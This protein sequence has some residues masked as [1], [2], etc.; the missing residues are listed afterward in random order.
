MDTLQRLTAGGRTV[1]GA[2]NVAQQYH[3]AERDA[4]FGQAFV[5]D[6]VPSGCRVSCRDK[7]TGASKFVRMAWF[8]QE[9]RSRFTA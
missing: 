4:E 5:R 7:Q 2:L 9:Q 6:Y 1:D 3:N 8:R